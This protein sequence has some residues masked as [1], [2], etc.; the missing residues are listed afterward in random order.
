M[1]CPNCEKLIVENTELPREALELAVE[2]KI[3]K[4]AVR[5]LL[6]YDASLRLDAATPP[7]SAPVNG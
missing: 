7:V 2:L 1:T 5:D 6:A 4:E 3:L